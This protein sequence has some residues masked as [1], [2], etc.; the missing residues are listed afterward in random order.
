VILSFWTSDPRSSLSDYR[1]RP[2]RVLASAPPPTDLVARYDAAPPG[3]LNEA[4][5][6]R[7]VQQ[8]PVAPLPRAGEGSC[9]R[10]GLSHQV[11]EDCFANRD[12]R[13]QVI[14]HFES[15]HG[16]G[17]RDLFHEPEVT[18][19]CLGIGEVERK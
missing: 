9:R 1:E 3:S 5:E 16:H 14:R 15:F 6:E 7:P 18:R 10:L 4:S 17:G 19:E 2:K 11:S 13:G 12:Y 8:A